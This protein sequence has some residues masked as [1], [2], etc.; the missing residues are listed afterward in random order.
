MLRLRVLLVLIGLSLLPGLL[1]AQDEPD[2]VP[3]PPGQQWDVYL[4]RGAG[5]DGRDRLSFINWL[6]GASPSLDVAGERYTAAGDRL[7]YFDTE[8]RQV[9]QVQAGGVPQP[10]PFMQLSD[11]AL[12]VDWTVDPDARH[13]AWTLTF[14]QG[15]GAL[16]TRT[17]FA[18]IDGAGQREVL[19]DGPRAGIRALPVA[20]SPDGQHLYMDAHP[21]GLGRFV[22]YMQYAGLFVLDLTT[23]VIEPL[24][25]EPAC[26]CGAG[27]GAGHLVRLSL[28]ED[29]SGFDLNIYNLDLAAQATVEAVRLSNYTQAGDVLIAPD[30][31][32]A[33]YA[34]SQVDAFGTEDQSVQTVFML[35]DMLAHTQRPLSDPIATYVHP[36]AWTEENAAILLTSP[37]TSGTWKMNL[38]AG[39]LVQ[40]ASATYLGQLQS[41]Y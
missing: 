23:G 17:F 3:L 32:L 20:L 35:V 25:G 6:A 2:S 9:M 10:H 27:L 33:V 1:S 29:L 37:Q 21:D 40:V 16:L 12:R 15:G 13:L 18:S 11:G 4:E 39:D 28:T 36:V 22:A 8:R 26:F 24:P 7:I 31:S 30:G 41:A 5:L 34:L 19:V 38:A 14:E